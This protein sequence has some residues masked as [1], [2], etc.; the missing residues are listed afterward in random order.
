MTE[1]DE[2]FEKAVDLVLKRKNASSTLIQDHLKLGY[3]RAARIM[4][5]LENMGMIGPTRGAMPRVI[6]ITKDSWLLDRNDWIEGKYAL[7]EQE[8]DSEQRGEDPDPVQQ[9][10]EYSL[11]GVSDAAS[12][13][14]VKKAYYQKMK[15]YHPDKTSGL[16]EKLKNLALEES[17]KIN[18]AYE[19]IKKK[20]GF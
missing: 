5:Q 12:I 13:E 16:G 11:L 19:A 17:K 10:S 3:T 20:K 15:E 1:L 18:G 2:L 7:P 14:D 9:E 8:P 6:L 4:E